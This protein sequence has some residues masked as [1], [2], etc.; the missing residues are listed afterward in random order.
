MRSSRRMDCRA[1]FHS[2]LGVRSHPSQFVMEDQIPARLWTRRMLVLKP[3]YW[4]SSSGS[5]RRSVCSARGT[6]SSA[7]VCT[8]SGSRMSR[9][10]AM[11]MS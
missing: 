11:S 1:A 4:Y 3:V 7:L 6:G 8:I 9:P 2:A 10:C 5:Q